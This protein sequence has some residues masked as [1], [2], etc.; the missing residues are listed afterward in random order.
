MYWK[1]VSTEI[2][3]SNVLLHAMHDLD[4][5]NAILALLNF[6]SEMSRH[7]MVS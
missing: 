2:R 6:V 5:Q 1:Y 3:G 7:A 4:P